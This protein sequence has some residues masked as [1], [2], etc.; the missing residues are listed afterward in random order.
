[1][2][3]YITIPFGHKKISLSGLPYLKPKLFLS[4]AE[5]LLLSPHTPALH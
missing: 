2:S 3:K 5:I 1:M 4:Q